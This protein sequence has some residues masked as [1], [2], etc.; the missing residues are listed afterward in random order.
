VIPAHRLAVA[1]LALLL[2]GCATPGMYARAYWADR[3]PPAV[4]LARV[5]FFPQRQF[6]CGPAALATVLGAAGVTVVP[7]ELTPEV[8]LPDRRGSLQTELV[9]AARRRGRLPVVLR[10]DHHALLDELGAGRPVLVLQNLGLS[11]LPRWH[12]AVV[13][14]YDVE[15]DALLLRSGT[16]RRVV[17]PRPRFEGTWNRAGRWAVVLATP[18]EV[19]AS[20]R[21]LDYV[22]AVVD[23]EATSPGAPL[24]VAWRAGLERWPDEPLLLFGLANRRASAGDGAAAIGLLQRLLAVDPGHVAS[25]STTART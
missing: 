9:A 6:Q 1:A 20:A 12:Y 24:D 11:F 4:E 21:P 7:D 15:R 10:S 22:R 16:K 14:G 8:F 19:P 13:I 25:R 23:L 5:P 18:G 17:L 2:A 3:A